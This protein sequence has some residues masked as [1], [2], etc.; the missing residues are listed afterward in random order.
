MYYLYYIS[1]GAAAAAGS[2]TPAVINRRKKI[3]GHYLLWRP[4]SILIATIGV[5]YNVC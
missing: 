2:N 3:R 4:I 5:L 1:D